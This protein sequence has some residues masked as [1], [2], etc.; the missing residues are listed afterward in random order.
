M[1]FTEL[2]Y[3]QRQHYLRQ[4]VQAFQQI[5]VL[6]GQK[7]LQNDFKKNELIY[8]KVVQSKQVIDW[9]LLFEHHIYHQ[10]QHYNLIKKRIKYKENLFFSIE[11]HLVVMDVLALFLYE[12]NL[13]LIYLVHSDQ[14]HIYHR[15]LLKNLKQRKDK[16][17][18][19]S[20]R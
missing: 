10:N 16:Y 2:E 3:Y 18:F 6:K 11:T 19:V 13:R 12:K 1:I 7:I 15:N 8:Q 20:L 4:V 17:V 14:Y 9:V 5:F